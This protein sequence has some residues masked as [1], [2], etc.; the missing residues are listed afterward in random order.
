VSDA[1]A[2]VVSYLRAQDHLAGVTVLGERPADAADR[3]P[4]LVIEQLEELPA[5]RL[6]RRVRRY[7]LGMQAWASPDADILAEGEPELGTAPALVLIR[8]ALVALLAARAVEM[9]G[10]EQLDR[11]G[12][13]GEPVGLPG[14]AAAVVDVAVR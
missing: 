8:Q 4:L 10:G 6:W 5:G 12:L 2:L 14:R 1:V 7:R 11:V 9:P 13:R 3:A